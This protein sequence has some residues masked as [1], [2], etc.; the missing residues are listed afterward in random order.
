MSART[1][2]Q[3]AEVAVGALE[4]IEKLTNLG[5]PKADAALIGIKAVLD[6]LKDGFDGKASAQVVLSRIETLHAAIEANDLE[7]LA[8]IQKRFGSSNG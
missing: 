7:A 1:M 6:S 2:L 5:G 3:M 8:E 4:T